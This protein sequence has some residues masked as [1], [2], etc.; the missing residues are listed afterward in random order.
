MAEVKAHEDTARAGDS[1]TESV[2]QEATIDRDVIKRVRAEYVEMPGLQ[3]TLDQAVRLHGL[4]RT[5]CQAV[6]DRLVREMFL[7]VKPNGTYARLTCGESPRPHVA[8]ADLGAARRA[9]RAS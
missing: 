5:L 1:A 7:W 6:M 9:P 3:L 8:K 2:A 4:D